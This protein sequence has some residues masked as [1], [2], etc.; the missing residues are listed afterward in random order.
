MLPLT[1]INRH[2]PKL[3]FFGFPGHKWGTNKTNPDRI[4]RDEFI[5]PVLGLWG[6]FRKPLLRRNDPKMTP[7]T[8]AI[9]VPTHDGSIIALEKAATSTTTT[10]SIITAKG[11]S[12]FIG[13]AFLW[14]VITRF[15][16]WSSPADVLL[17]KPGWPAR[18]LKSYEH[19]PGAS[20]EGASHRAGEKFP[21]GECHE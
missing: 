17:G 19:S 2:S 6:Y 21:K 16:S 4:S 1:V 7:T 10:T 3:R 13:P 18:G 9:I 8:H 20:P 15:F 14:H 5:R 12:S 11:F